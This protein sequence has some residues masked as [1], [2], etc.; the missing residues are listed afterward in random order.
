MRLS[1]QVYELEQPLAFV[2]AGERAPED[3]LQYMQL[4]LN[5]THR[6][7]ILRGTGEPFWVMGTADH[8]VAEQ[9]MEQTG[10]DEG[11]ANLQLLELS[12]ISSPT[13]TEPPYLAFRAAP[14]AESSTTPGR[15]EN[16][17][18]DL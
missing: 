16:E 9:F 5:A 1:D 10:M 8:L 11:S 2:P 12:V 3:L 15:P 7:W 17:S 6:S 14:P 18:G 4:Q 13:L